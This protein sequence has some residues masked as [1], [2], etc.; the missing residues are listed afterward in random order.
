MK[1]AHYLVLGSATLLLA[2]F[3]REFLRHAT[4]QSHCPVCKDDHPDRIKRPSWAKALD[5]I[6]P[7]QRFYCYAC[8]NR[9]IRVGKGMQ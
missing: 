2:L 4:F 6:V 3:I 9:F 7:S 8:G 1:L 5:F